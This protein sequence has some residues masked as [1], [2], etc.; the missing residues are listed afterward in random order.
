MEWLP[1]ALAGGGPWALLGGVV[2][3]VLGLVLKGQL[4][5]AAEVD[6]IVKAYERVIE[7]K[8]NDLIGWKTAHALE[9]EAGRVLREQNNML[10]EHSGMSAQAWRAIK[11][12]AESQTDDPT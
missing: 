3:T 9:V 6:R 7:E 1:T 8:N 11:A 2:F 4:V 5:P 10:L 12:A